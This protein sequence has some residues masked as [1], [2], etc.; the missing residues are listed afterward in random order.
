MSAP[1]LQ[2][3]LGQEATIDATPTWVDISAYVRLE[4]GITVTRGSTRGGGTQPGTASLTL[5]NTDARFTVGNTGSPYYPYVH[6]QSLVKILRDGRAWFIGRAQ[7]MPLSWPNGGDSEC[8]V[9]VTLADRLARLGRMSIRSY[10]VEEIIAAQFADTYWPLTES[11]GALSASPAASYAGWGSMLP[12]IT[13]DATLAF[14]GATGPAGDGGGAVSFTPNTGMAT[15]QASSPLLVVG[16]Y[17]GPGWG[18]TAAFATTVGGMLAR[19]YS[20]MG[21]PYGSGLPSAP[22]FISVSIESYLSVMGIMVRA[23]YANDATSDNWS[24][25]PRGVTDGA[26]HIIAVGAGNL[27][28]LQVTIDGVALTSTASS[29]TAFAWYM[30]A[31]QTLALGGGSTTRFGTTTAYTGTLSHVTLQFITAG[32]VPFGVGGVARVTTALQSTPVTTLSALSK[33]LEWRGQDVAGGGVALDAGVT[34]SV[35][36]SKIGGGTV[37]SALSAISDSEAGTLYVSASD[38]ITWRNRSAPLSPSITLTNNDIDSGVTYNHDIQG[39]VTSV[40]WN[41]LGTSG[42]V[43]SADIGTIGEISG[44][45]TSISTVMGD[46]ESH[47]SMLANTSPRGPYIGSLTIDMMTAESAAATAVATAGILTKITLTGMPAQ[48]PPAS[49]VLEI[50]GESETI[51]HSE[52]RV[53]YTTKPA[54]LG[55][56]RDLLI[57]DDPVYGVTDST[58]RVGY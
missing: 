52:W 58:H 31:S 30:R 55:S 25:F 40:T 19:V 1:S 43:E 27:S 9:Q 15:L 26:T 18:V 37:A 28:G 22:A 34:D 50:T 2:V 24:F 16:S 12:S 45:V 20:G 8:Y 38:V 21:S 10:A 6:L 56:G 32:F 48:T 4:R 46:G 33:V 7:S 36:P 13:G 39:L 23:Y 54:G 5:D 57:V 42:T 44:S 3:F 29:G 49:T 11:S 51:S 41:Q 47:A 14:G 35:L 53:T 17:D